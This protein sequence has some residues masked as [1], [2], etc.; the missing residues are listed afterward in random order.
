MPRKIVALKPQRYGT[1]QLVAGE[2]Y[3]LPDKHALVLIAAKKARF[4]DKPAP[5]KRVAPAAP[6]VETAAAEEVIE[7]AGRRPVGAMTTADF[8]GESDI[9]ALRLQA[10]ALGINVDGRWGRARLQYEIEQAQ[11]IR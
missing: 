8:V 6:V 2:E 1:R 9:D 5:A 11:A 4:A 7:H 3:E 10:T